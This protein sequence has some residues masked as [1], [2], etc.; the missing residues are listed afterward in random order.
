MLI[1]DTEAGA[2]RERCALAAR[3]AAEGSVTPW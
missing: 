3:T 1:I 2:G